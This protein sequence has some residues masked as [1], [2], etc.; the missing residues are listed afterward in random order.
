MP[1]I[2]VIS[3]DLTGT[4]LALSP[5]LGKICTDAARKAGVREEL[6]AD[7]LDER[8][9][10]ARRIIRA[11]G[12]SPVSEARSRDYWRA[13]LWE[14]FAGTVPT[15]VFP[16]VCETVYRRLADAGTWRAMRG[17]KKALE[18][19]RF[20]GLRCVALSN[21]DSRWR[22]ALEKLG[23]APLFDKI[24]ISSETGLA[25]P[26]AKAFDN[27]CLAMKIRRGELLHV[28]DSLSADIV[29]A[30]ELGAEAVWITRR[31]DGAPPQERVSV[32][33]SLD[34]LPKILQRRLCADVAR[35]HFPRSTRNLL[36]RLRGLPEEQ[37]PDPATIV[38]K[39]GGSESVARKFRRTEEAAFTTNREFVV[40]A[41]TLDGILRSRGIFS[42]SIQSVVRE[43]WEKVVPAELA[44]RCVPAELRDGMT[45]LVVACESAVARNELEF[46]KRAI[47]KKIRALPGCAKIGKIAYAN[48]LSA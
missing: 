36:A 3:F 35:E 23:L 46:R 48:D 25:K 9:K 30:Y 20:L 31:P 42:G 28:G 4:L 8:K 1:Q 12:F 29:P 34:E 37:T 33:D 15:A 6:S 24:F 13:M 14:I 19:A 44:A 2:R 11:N 32:I 7:T 39:K 10:Q 47:L 43:N 16:A 40:P 41:D 45:T 18:S 21:G 27:V 26:D 38:A 17:A 5:S 22:N